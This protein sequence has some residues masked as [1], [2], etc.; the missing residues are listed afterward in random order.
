MTE[1]ARLKTKLKNIV[2]GKYKSPAKVRTNFAYEEHVVEPNS[3]FNNQS[4]A[5][6]PTLQQTQDKLKSLNTFSPSTNPIVN[7]M[8]AI[9]IM[10]N[11]P[12]NP[13]LQSNATASQTMD[14]SA[15][16][17]EKYKHTPKTY[18]GY[19]KHAPYVT[20]DERAWL[21]KQ[22]EAVATADDYRKEAEKSK[23]DLVHLD[24]LYNDAMR[25]FTQEDDAIDKKIKGKEKEF[26]SFQ[27]KAEQK[28]Y[29]SRTKDILKNDVKAR[30]IIEQYY[31][32]KNESVETDTYSQMMNGGK[33]DSVYTSDE[34]KRIIQNFNNLAQKGYNPEELYT[35]YKRQKEAE[36]SS[37]AIESLKKE[38]EERPVAMSA[39][40]TIDNAVGSIGDAGK[41]IG[42]GVIEFVTGEK[43]YIDTNDTAA[44]RTQ[45]IR[46]AVSEKIGENI[47]DET[48]SGVAQFLYQTGM[49]M[50]DF[51]V[52]LP[53]NFI[54]GI[55]QGLQLAVLS[56]SAGT[57]A[58]KEAY[59]NTG[60]ASNALSTGLVAGIAETLLEKVSIDELFK[61]FNSKDATTVVNILK[62]A[63]KQSGVEAIEEG[64]TNI[65]NTMADGLINGDK[66]AFSLEY[67]EYISQGLS[68]D[69]AMQKCIAS[70]AKQL[71]LDAAGGALSG[72]VIGGG[73]STINYAGIKIDTK[74]ES[75]EIGKEY[76]AREDFDVN[77]LLSEAKAS[78]NPKAVSIANA[79]EKQ[80]KKN[81]N[82]KVEA[83]DVGNLVKLVATSPKAETS[84]ET[85]TNQ[86]ETETNYPEIQSAETNVQQNAEEV[87]SYGFGEQH[88]NGVNATDSKGNQLVIRRI[89]SSARVYGEAD[90]RV[91]VM[92][93]DGKIIDANELT[94]NLPQYNELASAAKN[95]DTNG[96]RAL[97]AYYESYADY[98]EHKTNMQEYLEGFTKLYEAGRMG[99]T[100]EN[101]KNHRSYAGYIN[102][103]GFTAARNALWSGDN[104]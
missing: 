11:T 49:S 104:D 4:L 93:T 74:R 43:Q 41:Y 98:K 48:A 12:K 90:N 18:E 32:L 42:A 79:I 59:D 33:T 66:S 82:Y 94:F 58:A 89:E 14:N 54:P 73:A 87:K 69:E 91:K 47:D 46:G 80:M 30:T 6:P 52:T 24:S 16:Y 103:I 3:N 85:E 45:A 34:E 26:A 2:T 76:M 68:E 27:E 15:Q 70:L 72:G 101:V 31:R 25:N 88:P 84:T 7:K 9:E 102:S 95:F 17:E 39:L 86:P 5:G 96:A 28:E 35:Y 99:G 51:L 64:S 71:A 100:W 22:A 50:A 20:D 61:I 10:A 63:A 29:E 21:E 55:G 75:Q 81:V 8:R 65:I 97:V 38:A 36:A 57:S 19:M 83:V 23:A 44:A 77:A 37:Y 13:V 53:L 67:Q 62:N 60:K 40:S 1:Y 78:S 92:T 56:T